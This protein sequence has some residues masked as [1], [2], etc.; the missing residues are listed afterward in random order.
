MCVCVCVCVSDRERER[1]RERELS[2]CRT[3]H[4]YT[5]LHKLNQLASCYIPSNLS[6]TVAT[7]NVLCVLQ[8]L[9]RYVC[10][11]GTRVISKYLTQDMPLHTIHSP[12]SS[13]HL[14]R[15]SRK[16]PMT[17]G[18]LSSVWFVILSSDL[19]RS[20]R[21]WRC[22]HLLSEDEGDHNS[23]CD[24]MMCSGVYLT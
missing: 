17:L 16:S 22:C 20:P 12:H 15:L 3:S 5:P 19:L 6:S 14:P 23:T 18:E 24:D 9:L 2:G 4:A 21:S 11:P 7:T 1:E 8:C 13:L 10:W